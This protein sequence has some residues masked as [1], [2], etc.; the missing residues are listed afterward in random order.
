MGGVGSVA[1]L[2]RVSV[3]CPIFLSC[4]DIVRILG[5]MRINRLKLH[6][7][8]MEILLVG[9]SLVLGTGCTYTAARWEC[10][11]PGGRHLLGPDLLLE[12]QVAAVARSSYFPLWLVRQ[13]HPC[14]GKKDLASVTHAL[15]TSQLNYCNMLY[16]A[17]P[18][19]MTQK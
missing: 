17:L 13:L 19:K 7:K 9:S 1:V 12:S 3:R 8:K 15:V 14:L 11:L 2:P 10:I 5:C 16:V 6:P 18:L 4:A